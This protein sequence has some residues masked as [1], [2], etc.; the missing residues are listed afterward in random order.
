VLDLTKGMLGNGVGT[1]APRLE[2]LLKI[3]LFGFFL[4]HK[5]VPLIASQAEMCHRSLHFGLF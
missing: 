5:G 4:P 1:E 2:N 3:V